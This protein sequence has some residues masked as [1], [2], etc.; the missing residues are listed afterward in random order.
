MRERETGRKPR[1]RERQRER[2]KKEKNGDLFQHD[3]KD[4]Q[5]RDDAERKRE[6]RR[7]KEKRLLSLFVG[8]C[9]HLGTEG[10]RHPLGQAPIS[11]MCERQRQ[12]HRQTEPERSLRS[13]N[14]T[15]VSTRRK[16]KSGRRTET[17][18]KIRQ[19][20]CAN[21]KR[22]DWRSPSEL[23]LLLLRAGRRFFIQTGRHLIRKR[24]EIPSLSSTSSS[25]RERRR[26]RERETAKQRERERER[27]TDGKGGSLS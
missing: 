25:Q 12:A 6:R 17:S 3:R 4:A 14:S 2:E 11:L 19:R 5:A 8:R 16:K 22:V 24:I 9:K 15:V 21:Q 1:E 7:E 10:K 20:E 13:E 27:E 26:T 18:P 23:V